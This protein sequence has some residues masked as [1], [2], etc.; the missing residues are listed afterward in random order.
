MVRPLIAGNWKM[1]GTHRS[2]DLVRD[3]VSG[4][5]SLEDKAD[6]LVCPPATLLGQVSQIAGESRLVTGGQDCHAEES[7]AHTGDIAAEMIAD[8][9]A[10]Y[11]IIGHSER[12]SDHGESD[13]IVAAKAEAAFR[14]DLVPI[15]CVGETLEER[16]ADKTIDVISSQLKNSIPDSAANQTFVVAYEPVWAIGTGKVA[17]PGQV[18]EVHDEIRK[19]LS[20]RFG[21]HG[22]ER[23]LLY[24]G[25]MKPGNAAELLALENVN[26]G[27]IGGA[28]LKAEDFLAIYAACVS[29]L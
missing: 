25:S 8:M 6:C 12:R 14:A 15:I 28:S 9:G 3:V 13:A 7:G 2:L 17:T 29:N 18:A 19:Q 16:E 4:L 22:D 26:G 27:L 23:P 21:S 5:A 1:N 11:V 24:G 20:Q 10:T